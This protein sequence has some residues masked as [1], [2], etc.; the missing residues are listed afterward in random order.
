MGGRGGGE[1]K[2]FGCP[3]LPRATQLAHE[4]SD[5]PTPP[6][7]HP[8][9]AC[10]TCRCDLAGETLTNISTCACVCTHT[11]THTNTRMHTRTCARAHTT[12]RTTTHTHTHIH[13]LNYQTRAVH[14]S[15]HTTFAGMCLP[16]LLHARA[17]VHAAMHVRTQHACAPCKC[18]NG[19][20]KCGA[21]L[22]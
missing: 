15:T 22:W 20:A 16:A 10:D 5:P 12:T 4:G 19:A 21:R 7:S 2:R 9:R 11:H 14:K 8:M 3:P 18:C 13:I 6:P 17:C 1:S